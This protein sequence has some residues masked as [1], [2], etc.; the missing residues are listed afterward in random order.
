[1]AGILLHPGMLPGAYGIGDFGQGSRDFLDLLS[2]MQVSLWQILPLGPTGYGDSPYAAR[3]SF[4]GNELLIDLRSL[5]IEGFLDIDALLSAPSFPSDYVD[6]AAVRAWKEPLLALAAARFLKTA[7]DTLMEEFHAFCAAQAGWLEDYALYEVLCVHYG[8]SRW[9]TTWDKDIALRKPDALVSWREKKAVELE[10]AKIRQFFFFRQW[11]AVRSYA[12][13][14]GISIIGDLPIY[15]A[16]DSADAWSHRELLSFS[17]DGV[18]TELGGVPPDAFSATGQLWGNPVYAWEKHEEDGFAWWT[19]R[20]AA[21]FSQVDILRLDHFRGFA[22]CWVVPASASTAASGRWVASPGTRLLAAAREKLGNMDIIAEDL[23]VITPD[24]EQLR[25][26]NGFPGMK[27]LQFAFEKKDGRFNPHHDYLPHEYDYDSAA[28]TGTHDN[29]TSRGWFSSLSHEYKD[30]VRCY[31]Q[32]D[33][34]DV[35]WQM[36]RVIMMSRAR[37]AVFPIQDILG[38]GD[39]ARFNTPGTCGTHNWGWRMNPEALQGWMV[40]RFSG[41]VTMYGRSTGQA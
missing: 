35:V 22:A 13:G 7:D 8:D 11:Q 4:A 31:L 25:V 29:Q 38:C 41:M 17:P 37:Y 18:Q 36:I 28:Y 2:R 1:M 9:F 23:G 5:A 10:N 19:R 39:E 6:Y 33:D 16:A 32:C 21:A 34:G 20:L 30:M 27:I 12:H 26:E 24:V 3:S 15:V 40:E 14:K